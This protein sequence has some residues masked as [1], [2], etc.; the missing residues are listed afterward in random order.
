MTAGQTNSA[1]LNDCIARWEASGAAERAN[2]LLYPPVLVVVCQG[3]HNL[4][5]RRRTAVRRFGEQSL[6]ID[7]SALPSPTPSLGACLYA[8]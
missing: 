1:T 7:S 3:R 2:Y 4:L 5:V 6:T 8:E